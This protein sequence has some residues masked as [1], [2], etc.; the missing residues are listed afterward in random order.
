MSTAWPLSRPTSRTSGVSTVRPRSERS[1]M[2]EEAKVWMCRWIE[3]RAAE[4]MPPLPLSRR[5]LGGMARS[6]SSAVSASSSLDGAARLPPSMWQANH[7]AVP[8]L[9]SSLSSSEEWGA[10]MRATCPTSPCAPCSAG[11]ASAGAASVGAVSAGAASVGV[12]STGAASVGVPET[13]AA[14]SAVSANTE[15]CIGSPRTPRSPNSR[16]STIWSLCSCCS[17]SR[18]AWTTALSTVWAIITLG[19]P[20]VY[21]SSTK[22]EPMSSSCTPAVAI[23][24]LTWPFDVRSLRFEGFSG[25]ARRFSN[26]FV[27]TATEANE[28]S[29]V[30]PCAQFVASLVS[31]S[32]SRPSFCLAVSAIL[33]NSCACPTTATA[34]LCQHSAAGGISRDR[35]PS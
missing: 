14:V 6:S 20:S 9:G 22:P 1:T 15:G 12:A 24:A 25:S 2:P 26:T 31:H 13:R 10:S 29:S 33:L 16:D 19:E 4:V 8:G 21:C 11:G 23:S 17:R 35:E 5:W 34:S 27:S 28:P 7:S 3:S 32:N 18:P 30:L